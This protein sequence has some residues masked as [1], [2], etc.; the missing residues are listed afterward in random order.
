MQS[1]ARLWAQASPLPG[2]RTPEPHT[3]G[4]TVLA[5]GEGRSALD[6]AQVATLYAPANPIEHPATERDRVH[7]AKHRARLK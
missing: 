5:K 1:P 6:T 2:N 4:A 3:G 7:L